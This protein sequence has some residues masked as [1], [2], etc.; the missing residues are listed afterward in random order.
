MK[1]RVVASEPEPF[2]PWALGGVSPKESGVRTVP[3]GRM[4]TTCVETITP[5]PTNDREVDYS[6]GGRTVRFNRL[7]VPKLRAILAL[8]EGQ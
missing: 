8:L 3:P 6:W 1:K 4:D 5:H 7:D 2:G